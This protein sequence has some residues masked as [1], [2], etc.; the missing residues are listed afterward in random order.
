[1]QE[2]RCAGGVAGDEHCQVGGTQMLVVDGHAPL[3]AHA[4]AIERQAR[5]R[6]PASDRH[7]DARDA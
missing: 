2:R 1:V 4:D 5:E 3:D 7:Q 6:R